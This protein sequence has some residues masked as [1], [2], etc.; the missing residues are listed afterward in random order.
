MS[1]L[2]QPDVGLL[3]AV[4]FAAENDEHGWGSLE[5]IREIL[6]GSYPGD[7]LGAALENLR[8]DRYVSTDGVG[9]RLTGRGWGYA[10]E[11]L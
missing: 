3:A 11:H 1:G 4:N 9:W 5:R 2:P 6:G 7:L 8:G 10:V